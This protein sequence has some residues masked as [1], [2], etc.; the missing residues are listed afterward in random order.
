VQH[1]DVPIDFVVTAEQARACKPDHRLFQH[2]WSVMGMAKE[3]TVHVGMGQ[4]TDLKVCHELNIRSVWIDRVGEP[5]N[6]DW[7]PDTTLT[8]LLGCRNCCFRP[9]VARRPASRELLLR[10]G[11]RPRVVPLSSPC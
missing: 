6:P 11:D 10:A 2:A 5:I 1:S 8:D 4:F 9:D 3:E 7:P